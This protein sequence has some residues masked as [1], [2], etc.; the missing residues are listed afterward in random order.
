MTTLWT[1]QDAAVATGGKAHGDWVANGVS[2]DTRT[3]QAG[4]LFVALKDV[5]DGH[6]FVAM[7]LDKGAAAAL[8][9]HR[10]DGVADDAPLLVVDDVLTALEAMGRAARAR[11]DAKVIGGIY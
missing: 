11:T 8:V 2:I 7:A 5:R 4:E 3:I 1:A 6:D 9:T 10:P